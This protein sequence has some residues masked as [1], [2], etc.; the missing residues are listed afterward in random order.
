MPDGS[1]LP[2]VT[3]RVANKDDV[4]AVMELALLCAKEGAF[5]E[6]D[7]TR[8]LEGIYSALALDSGLIGVIDGK[9]GKLEGTI[10][11][12]I[13]PAWYGRKPYLEEKSVFVHPDFRSAKGGRAS[14]LIEFAKWTADRLDMKLFMG[15]V[16]NER[17]SGKI[18]FYEKYLGRPVGAIWLY[19]PNSAGKKAKDD[20][21]FLCSSKRCP[22]CEETKSLRAF[23]RDVT[24][25]DRLS[26][27]CRRCCA[28]TEK[29]PQYRRA[30]AG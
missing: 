15:I 27:S 4:H 13:G 10:L 9:D 28:E 6:Y 21:W 3:V 19:E 16:S 26:L 20:G 5:V 8:L 7:Q 30:R 1:T 14:R 22:D 12:T 23:R 29:N 18:R 24:T 25:P 11:L 17:T 2:A